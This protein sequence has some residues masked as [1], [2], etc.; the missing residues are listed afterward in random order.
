MLKII[1]TLVIA[2]VILVP[3]F[4]TPLGEALYMSYQD[5]S[6]HKA[7][8]CQYVDWFGVDGLGKLNYV[9]KCKIPDLLN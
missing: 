4:S 8:Y 1:L 9:L 7:I 6:L 3:F 2:F 5:T